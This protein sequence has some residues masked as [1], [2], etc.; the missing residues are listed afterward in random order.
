MCEVVECTG[1]AQD[2]T[3][4]MALVRERTIT[5]EPPPLV[6]VRSYFTTE[7]SQSVCLGIGHPCGTS[8]QILLILPV[9]MLLSEICGLVS[10][11]L[12]L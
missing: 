1:L 9:G 10:V 7:V 6:E 8:N 4:S 5:T 11:G 12:P 3:N 2:L